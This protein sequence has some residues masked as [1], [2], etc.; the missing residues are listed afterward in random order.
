[1]PI[2]ISN[3]QRVL[4]AVIAFGLGW[5]SPFVPAVAAQGLTVGG[6]TATIVDDRG[7]PLRGVSITLERDGTAV[8]T[9]VADRLGVASYQV[10]APGLYSILAEEF[11]FQPVRMTAIA[12]IA[13]SI[14][15]VSI[16]LVRRPPPIAAVEERPSNAAYSTSEPF[17]SVTGTDLLRFDRRTD[18]TNVAEAFSD[19][20]VPRDGRDGLVQSAN[21][22]APR[23]SSLMVDGV[24]ES[25][26]RHPGLP[27]EPAT[28]PLFDRNG[29]EQVV[30]TGFGSDVDWP[31]TPGA[32][33]GAQTARG[34]EHFEFR[35]WASFSSAKLGGRSLDNPGDSAATSIRGGVTVG[36]P[37]KRDTA[38]WQVSANYQQLE[39][40]APAPSVADIAGVDSGNVATAIGA[41]AT[42][43]HADVAR[44]L[45]PTVRTWKGGSGLGRLD[46]QLGGST[47]L[48]I[49][50]GVAS[51]S[52]DNP[53]VGTEL[54][55]GAGSRLEAR[56]VSGSAS[57][58]T[59][60][61]SVTSESRLGV[62]TS[63]RDWTGAS[64]PYTGFVGDG[65]AVGGAVTLPGNFSE[66]AFGIYETIAVRAGEHTLKFGGSFEHRTVN[67]SWLPGG[68]GRYLFGDLATFAADSGT[69]YRASRSTPAPDLGITDLALFVEDA[70]QISPDMQIFGGFRYDR[71]HLPG[72]AV[73]LNTAWGLASNRLNNLVPSDGKGSVFGPRGGVTWDASGA[74]RTVLR[75]S[76]GMVPG[77]FDV[78]ALAEAAQ[79]DG[80]VRIRRAAGN[81]AWPAAGETVGVDAGPA[82]TMFGPD[83]RKPLAFKSDLSLSQRLDG[84]TT[85][86][87]SGGYRHTDYLLRREDLNRV[88]DPVSTGSDGRPIYGTLLQF[89]GLIAPAVG[90][91]R[92]F[93]E[94]DMAYGLSS[95]GYADDYE[96]GLSL[97]HRMT[98]GLSA[99]LSYT[100][101]KTTDNLP[102]QLSG[103]PADQLSPFPDGLKGGIWEDGRSDLDIPH[104]V[105]G[106]LTYTT[107]GRM[108]LILAA[109]Y[110]FR[111]G[112]PFTPGFRQGVD[113]NGDG[114]GNNDPAFIGNGILGMTAET[115]ANS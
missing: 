100:Y 105:A 29:L 39:S 42:A 102:G 71:E 97:E 109:R 12:V 41:A 76:V 21:G 86:V 113:A 28:A 30:F 51:W 52:E 49:R 88:E 55:N 93:S 98:R 77:R 32:T 31:A 63:K 65:L 58:T 10:V 80:D 96:L 54:V 83:V 6:L 7:A 70:W 59:G 16:T 62:R 48:A 81:V 101:S 18:V 84:A 4:A 95:T 2:R 91:N 17:Q 8:R 114:S 90:S 82:L 92:R 13:G 74:G 66:N 103:D 69:Y 89:G 57:L 44:W 22:L 104:R 53:D 73:A 37:I 3:P 25:L 87:V 24:R 20:D 99:L 38:A 26:L 47:L 34:G 33:L 61:S 68:S 64:L 106:T 36:G 110:R 112:L 79:Y 1:M 75:A 56:D 19:A 45:A 85:V 50:A 11:G 60:G 35:P 46:W 40:P 23:Y 115:G 107:G 94:F 78:A 5:A 111:S 9:L 67:D 27:G 14:S 15:R 72:D 43:Q 108:P